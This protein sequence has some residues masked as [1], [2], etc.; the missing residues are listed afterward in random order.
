MLLAPS[1]VNLL[2]SRTL[3]GVVLQYQQLSGF[4]RLLAGGNLRVILDKFDKAAYVNYMDINTKVA[5]SQNVVNQLPSVDIKLKQAQTA[6]Y[7]AQIQAAWS[8]W[9]VG[10]AS[11]WN[12]SLIEAQ[13]LGMRQ[14]IYQQIRNGALYGNNPLNGEG[15]LNTVGATVVGS[16]PADPFGNT[17][18]TTSDNGWVWQYLT[19]AIVNVKVRTNQMGRPSRI[20]ICGPQRV[21]SYWEYNVVTL[22]QYQRPGAGVS[23]IKEAVNNIVELN[24]DTVEWVYDDTLIGKGANGYDAV[25]IA[26]PE[27]EKPGGYEIDTNEFAKVQPGIADTIVQLCD[28][29]AP[30]EKYAPIAQDSTSLIMQMLLTSGWVIRP[31]CLTIQSVQYP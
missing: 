15:L 9:D 31:E 27:I 1:K 14:G 29:T 30:V 20:T 17:T 3:P 25:L 4:A 19:N 5:I 24:G 10:S 18:L 16:L 11:I 2:P 26:L 6:T 8:D 12:V 23:T 21:L 22:T 13:R 7:M 28:V